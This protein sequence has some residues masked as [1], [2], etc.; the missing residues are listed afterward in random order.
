MS[1]IFALDILP[2]AFLALMGVYVAILAFKKSQ[3]LGHVA[4][5]RAIPVI[6][7]G[8]MM[9]VLGGG[10]GVAMFFGHPTI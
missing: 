9:V 4:R 6:V 2:S 5:V 3:G 10:L 7:L 8:C 1:G